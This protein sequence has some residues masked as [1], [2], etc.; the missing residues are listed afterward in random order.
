MASPGAAVVAQ[1]P[2]LTVGTPGTISSCK[3]LDNKANT[4]HIFTAGHVVY[5][6]DNSF[7]ANQADN[8]QAQFF[9]PA[10]EVAESQYGKLVLKFTLKKE[11]KLLRLD[12]N[13]EGFHDWLKTTKNVEDNDKT[14]LYK[15]FGYPGKIQ[16]ELMFY[17]NYRK[18]VIT[19]KVRANSCPALNQR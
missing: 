4:F 19:K 17:G 3:H 8:Y 2:A 18:K 15:N 6:G 9:T 13:A 7:N 10:K 1:T 12:K 16:D 14:I 5:R 11:V